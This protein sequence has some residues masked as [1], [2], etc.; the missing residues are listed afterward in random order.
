MND[1]ILYSKYLYIPFT[2]LFFGIVYF[3][4]IS[5]ISLKE[6]VGLFFILLGLLLYFVEVISVAKAKER[7]VRKR[8]LFIIFLSVGL[9][10]TVLI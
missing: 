4:C 1:K 2:F 10:L 6:H 3:L 7:K 8:P 9:V 5:H